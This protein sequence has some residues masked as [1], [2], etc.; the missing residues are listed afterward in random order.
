MFQFLSH[1]ENRRKAHA[2]A[3]KFCQHILQQK[4]VLWE[5]I[6]RDNLS[7]PIHD[8]DMVVTIGGDGTLLQASHFVDSSIPILGVN[9]DP[10]QDEEVIICHFVVICVAIVL[11]SPSLESCFIKQGQLCAGRSI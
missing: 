5:A 10:T 8:V 7:R 1:L 4:P 9:S 2:E 11:G 6:S 3:I